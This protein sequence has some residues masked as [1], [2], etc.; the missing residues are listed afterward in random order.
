[1]PI[2]DFGLRPVRAYPPVCKPYGLEAALEGLAIACPPLP[3]MP[4]LKLAAVP[5]A[6]PPLPML[7]QRLFDVPGDGR[8]VAGGRNPK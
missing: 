1:M 8:R 4:A 6:C 5:G 7:A 3:R 2:L